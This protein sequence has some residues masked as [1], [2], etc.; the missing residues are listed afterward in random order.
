MA[1]FGCFHFVLVFPHV[2]QLVCA[3]QEI[4]PD[5]KWVYP[6]EKEKPPQVKP[7]QN[8]L[9]LS[10]LFQWSPRWPSTCCPTPCSPASS[11]QP[12]WRSRWW[13][14]SPPSWASTWSSSSTSPPHLPTSSWVS[15]HGHTILQH[16]KGFKSLQRGCKCCQ[17]RWL[18]CPKSGFSDMWKWVCGWELGFSCG[19][20][21]GP[22]AELQHPFSSTVLSTNII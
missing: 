13:P 4:T 6:S 3:E 10:P 19:M 9:S 1:L 8:H 16:S 18:S 11:W 22:R 7:T 2:K 5:V 15:N 17:S 21:A 20:A 12:A 14:A